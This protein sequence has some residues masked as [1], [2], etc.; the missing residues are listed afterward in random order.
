M[1]KTYL[2]RR[3]A[4]FSPGIAS[5]PISKVELLNE[6]GDVVGVSGSDTGRTL[7]ALQPDGTNAMAAAILAK[8][9]GYKHV[10]YEGSQALLDPAVE[11]GDAVTVDGLYVPLIALDITFDP[12]LAPDIS[13]PDADE[14]DDEYPYKS[15]TQ[16][17]IE[18][19]FAKAKTLITKT[20]EE[21][22]LKVEGLDG[23]VSDVTQTVDGISLSVTSSS[24]TDGETTA[25]ITLKVGPNNYTGYIKIDGNVN[26][27]GQLSADALYAAL[28][29]IADLTVD[30]LSTSRRVAK[31]L[32]GDKSDDNFVRIHDQYIE[33]VS[34]VYADGTAQAE[35]PHGAL[36]YWE[37]DPSGASIG[38]DGY[39]YVNGERIFTTTTKTNWPVMIYTYTELVKRSIAF[40]Q[41][42]SG[43]YTPVD[44]FGAGN[45]DGTN[46][47][48]MLKSADG[49]E[50]TYATKGGNQIGFMLG[51][52]GY[53]DIM[54]LRKSTGLN[55]SEWDSGRF[56]ERIDGD[57][58]RY[59]YNVEF[60][61]QGRPTKIADST[62]HETA[63]Y[64]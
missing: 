1:D 55:F 34:G 63:I 10:G 42:G 60:D 40:E 11:L 8:V 30:R 26:V 5:K 16:R 20:S 33:F 38:S 44:V 25:K 56:Y 58:T 54:G 4:K 32:A 2:G 39:P 21:I 53:T 14:L 31:Y 3:L 37:S 52:S 59:A 36:L 23:R 13:A 18:R 29:E 19:N 7:T 12:L 15:P 48:R 6:N 27:S 57:D 28:G 64:W 22:N 17:Q 62:G 50:L 41:D 9:S 35:N 45:A 43:T 49:L 46:K 24:S 47:A 61:A 51:N